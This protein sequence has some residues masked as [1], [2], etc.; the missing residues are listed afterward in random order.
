MSDYYL[1]FVNNK[2]LNLNL[3]IQNIKCVFD[4]DIMIYFMSKLLY[5]IFISMGDQFNEN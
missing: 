3:L 5:L 2:K 4:V 1:I